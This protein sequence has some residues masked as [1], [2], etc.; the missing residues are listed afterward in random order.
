MKMNHTFWIGSVLAAALTA[1]CQAHF[2][3]S[4]DFNDNSKDPGRWG[5]EVTAGVGL[6]TE[7]NGR[8][9]YTTGGVPTGWDLSAR[10]WMLSSGRYTQNWEV[11]IDVS[12]P[13]LT[14]GSTEFVGFG[15]VIFP[16]PDPAAANSNRFYADLS[17]GS[18]HRFNCN[19]A[20]NSSETVLGRK[21]TTSTLAAVRVGFDASTK[22]LSAFYDEDGPVGG[23]AWTLLGS[24][25]IPAG[26]QMTGTSVFGVMVMGHSLF[27]PVTSSTGVFGDNF[28]ASWG[29][30]GM[31][32]IFTNANTPGPPMALG[33]AFDGVNLLV[34]IQG[35]T[36]E[37]HN[38]TAQLLSPT[39]AA[40]GPRIAVAGTG[41][42]PAVSFDGTNHLLVWPDDANSTPTNYND[43]IYGQFISPSGTLVRSPIAIK[44]ALNQKSAHSLSAL[45]FDGVNYLTVWEDGRNGSL[46]ADVY[47]QFVSPA[48]TLVGAELPICVQSERQRVPSLACNGTNYLVVWESRRSG[49][50]E[51]WDVQGRF[52]SK[53]GELGVIFQISQT[54]SPSYN[55]PNLASDGTNFMVVYHRDTGPGYPSPTVWDIY[56]R[57]VT[58]AESFVGNEFPVVTA[59]G[60][61]VYPFLNWDGANYLVSWFDDLE[62]NTTFRFFNPVGQPA[63][64]EFYVFAAQG[65]KSPIA[66]LG[67]FDGKRFLAIGNLAEDFN[68]S[69]NDIYGAFVLGSTT[70]SRLEFTNHQFPF[71][72]IGVPG[73]D[74]AVEAATDLNSPITWVPLI[75][76]NAG[77]GTFS[78]TDTNAGSFTRRF[79][80]TVTP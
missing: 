10:P 64:Q 8:L 71:L 75:T 56:G 28:R 39:G 18:D 78:F 23:Y 32:P 34:G 1:E 13:Q 4:D 66:F 45:A 40:V 42:A 79:Y 21:A 47:G 46:N 3:G 74:Y 35:D 17:Q 52:V 76:N 61:Q 2:N 14:L 11:Q 36:N 38:I 20:V 73:Q 53:S 77:N 58:P 30:P 37:D 57:V 55:P 19:I 67:P 25:N 5:T 43:A 24:T 48:G 51:L 12:L 6:L 70:R 31:F 22:V 26:W 7:S 44:T 60:S 65:S 41:G 80:R 68:F 27:L 16:G 54:P 59:T 72:I 29:P 69:N 15:F 9:E 33:A 50:S 62:M 63:G 49:E